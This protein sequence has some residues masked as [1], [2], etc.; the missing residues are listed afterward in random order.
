[1]SSTIRLRPIEP[2]DAERLERF[3]ERLSEDTIYRRYHGPHPR[4]RE[5]EIRFLVGAHGDGHIAWVACDASNEIL[6]VC[7]VVG[8][9]SH[10]GHGEVGIV[11]AD[12]VQHVGIGRRLLTRVLIE[13]RERG[14]DS[15]EALILGTNLHARDLFVSVAKELGID[16]RASW[17]G[18]VLTLQ[19][20]LAP[21]GR[22]LAA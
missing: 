15:V 19:L 9:P 4:L 21:A 13:A 22:L 7:R 10:P 5:R 12:E 11:V 8:S 1:M 18:G 2:G 3:H 14:F 17:D 6:G 16:C 20:G